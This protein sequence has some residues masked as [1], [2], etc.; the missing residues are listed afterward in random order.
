[1]IADTKNEL[2]NAIGVLPLPVLLALDAGDLRHA[3]KVPRVPRG[4]TDQGGFASQLAVFIPG[5][6]QGRT[7]LPGAKR[8]TVFVPGPKQS[9]TQESGN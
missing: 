9:K 2:R 3:I 7:F 6:Q 4:R 5:P 1:M 8:L